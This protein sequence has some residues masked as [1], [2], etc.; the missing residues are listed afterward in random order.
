MAGPF[1]YSP[2]DDAYL[3][4]ATRYVER[5]PVR[6]GMVAKAEDYVWSSAPAHCGLIN[7][8]MLSRRPEWQKFRQ[9]IV[10]WSS[11]LAEADEPKDLEVLRRNV[12]KGL[13][14]GTENFVRRLEKIAGRSLQYRPTGRSKQKN[15]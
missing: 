5:N 9:Q 11:W 4:A 6:A 13:P 12:E 10:N 2:L 1:F 14:C 15:R 7:D 8:R 3:W